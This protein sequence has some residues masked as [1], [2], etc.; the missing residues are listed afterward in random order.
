MGHL[1]GKVLGSKPLLDAAAAA[2]GG[3]QPCS[4]CGSAMWW[5]DAYGQR[6]CRGC[7]PYPHPGMVAAWIEATADGWSRQSP[8]ERFGKSTETALPSRLPRSGDWADDFIDPATECVLGALQRSA[9][10][11]GNLP[12]QHIGKRVRIHGGRSEREDCKICGR[13]LGFPT[14]SPPPDRTTCPTATE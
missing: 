13:T 4:R 9:E 12:H 1:L 10:G 7:D 8:E 2:P 14:W 6:W 3:P 5:Q 11:G